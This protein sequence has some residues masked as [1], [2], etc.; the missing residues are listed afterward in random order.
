MMA[1]FPFFGRRRTEAVLAE[2]AAH[3]SAGALEAV[4]RRVYSR[5]STLSPTE[6]R[7][8][9]RARARL[10][11]HR[12]VTQTLSQQPQL[13]AWHARLVDLA[14]EATIE[15]VL[16]QWRKLQPQSTA[17]RRAA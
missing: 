9:I 8:Y 13:M 3:I 7:G 6:A 11:I 15:T 4:W 10:V 2:L 5:L 14:N 12:Q 16:R 1:L 17:A